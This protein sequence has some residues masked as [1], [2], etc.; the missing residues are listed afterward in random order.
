MIVIF[1]PD[2][3]EAELRGTLSGHDA[4]IVDGPSA[5]G[6]FA[7]RVPDDRRDEAA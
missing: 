1:R 5:S 3:T 2:V 6:A 7:L 4:R